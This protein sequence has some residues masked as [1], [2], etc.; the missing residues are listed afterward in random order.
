VNLDR[1][2][3]SSIDRRTRASD[4]L[5][6][7]F[8]KQSKKLAERLASGGWNKK[9]Q[10]EMGENVRT[11][12]LQ[13][14]VLGKGGEL[15]A[16]ELKVLD[17]RIKEQLS[18]LSRFADKNAA[19]RLTGEKLSADAVYNQSVLYGGAGRAQFYDAATRE[20]EADTYVEYISADDGGTC[21][22]CLSAEGRYSLGEA[23]LPGSVCLGGGRC[24]CRLE[25]HVD[26][27]KAQGL[28]A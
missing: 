7:E 14:A 17:A 20:A 5:Q 16:M 19:K 28:A 1:L 24:R 25:F 23:P 27:K 3:R 10:R 8:N 2:L 13:Q 15:T 12:M 11:H 18:Y 4:K 26:A 22:P 9:W 21:D 6:S